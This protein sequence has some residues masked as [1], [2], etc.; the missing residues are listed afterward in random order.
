MGF[1]SRRPLLPAPTDSLLGSANDT[2]VETDIGTDL[3]R[4][5]DKTSDTIPA[6]GTPITIAT[7]PKRKTPNKLT[8][9]RQQSQTS[10]LIEYFE[11][12]KAVESGQRRPSLRVR[13]TPSQSRKNKEKGEGHILVTES[14][15]ARRPSQSHRIVL[16]GNETLADNIVSSSISALDPLDNLKPHAPVEVE[17]LN[18]TESELSERSASPE[19]RYIVPESDISSMPAE[20]SLGPHQPIFMAS[21]THSDNF[22]RSPDGAMLKPPVIM[23]DRNSSQ[24][25]ITQKV[26]E[27]LSNKPRAST[28][29]KR[30]SSS[31]SGS[32]STGSREAE[33]AISEP[34][35]RLTKATDGDFV[36]SATNS[37][38][39]S[40]SHLSADPR[41]ADQ[42]SVRSGTSNV[43]ISNNPKLLKT[44]ED[45]IRRL[46]LP[47]LDE[48]RRDQKHTHRS[49]QE[50]LSNPSDVSSSTISREDKARR[51]SSGS[52]SARRVSRESE[53]GV[54]SGSSRRYKQHKSLDYDSPSEQSYEQSESAESNSIRDEKRSHKRKSHRTR[55]VAAG[56]LGG[57]AL[58]AAALKSHDSGSSLDHSEH[59]RRR[60]S[61][62]RSSRSASIAEKEDAFRKHRVPPMPFVSELGTD[63]TRSSIKSSHDGRETPTRREVREVIR[64]SPLESQSSAFF[65]PT[66]NSFDLK[67]GLGTHHGNFSEHDLSG[68]DISTRK[69]IVEDEEVYR[70][71]EG[72][73]GDFATHGFAALTDPERARAY[74]RNLHQ[75]HPIRRGL[76]PIQSVAS[77]QTTEPNRNSMMQQRSSETIGSFKKE[78]QIDDQVSI[79]SLSSPPST[80]LARSRRPHGISLENRSEIMAQHKAS[81]HSTPRQADPEAVFDEQHL[82]NESYRDAPYIDKVTAGQQLAKVAGAT[83]EYFEYPAGVE[84]AVASLVDPSVLDTDYNDSARFSQ[85]DS[86]TAREGRSPHYSQPGSPLKHEISQYGE[87]VPTGRVTMASPPQSPARSIEHLDDEL[88]ESARSVPGPEADADKDNQ[89]ERSPDSDITTNPSIIRGPIGGLGEGNTDH[90]PYDPTPPHSR[91]EA[92]LPPVSRDIHSAGA[93]LIPEALS[94]S[95]DHDL[96][97][98]DDFYTRTRSLGTPTSVKDEGYETGA[99]ARSPGLY[100]NHQDPRHENDPQY[101]GLKNP[102]LEDD[103]FTGKREKYVSGLSHGLSPMYDSATGRG[104]DNIQSKDIVALM[105]HLTTRDAQRNARDTEILV[106]LVRSAAEM[107][108]S[109]EDMKKFIAEQDD[110]VMDTAEKQHER[111][112]K[113]VGGP[114]PQPTATPRTVQS[115][116]PE[117]DMPSKRR[118]VFQRALRGLG[119]KNTQELQNIE[120]MLMRLLDEVEALRTIQVPNNTPNK[121][122]STSLASG[123]N[124]RPLTDTGYE[125][126]GQAG[127]SSTGDRSGFFSNN[128]SRQA[129]HRNY[130]LHRDSGNRVSTVIE[131]DEEY[132][133]Y[134]MPLGE[135]AAGNVQATVQ[136]P[137]RNEVNQQARAGSA[138]LKTP[139]RLHERNTGSLSNE[140][141]PHYSAGDGSGRKH[142]SSASSFVPKMFSRWSKTTTSSADNYRSSTQRMRPQSEMSRSGSDLGEY[143]FEHDPQGDDR[144]RSQHSLQQD[145]YQD[146]ENRPPSPLIPSQMSDNPKY[147]AHRNS[148][149]L[150]HPQPR[151]G[152]TGRFQSR[153]ESEAQL[154]NNQISPTSQTSSQFETYAGLQEPNGHAAMYGGHQ[155]PMSDTQYDDRSVHSASSQGPPRPPKILNEDPL[156]PQRPPKISMNSTQSNRQHTYVD[157]VAAARAGS[158]AL[159][160]S[161]VAALRSPQGQTRKPSGPRPLNTAGGPKG[162]SVTVKRAHFRSSPT[163]VDS[164]DEN[165]LGY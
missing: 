52:K 1:T 51:R 37:S 102:P 73:D 49:R 63:I 26:I 140:N 72:E 35:I 16:G 59:R 113:V 139:P 148:M 38:L 98:T 19:P 46:I 141:T 158:P 23:A 15:T 150:Q 21:S 78:Q 40:G 47:E 153:L 138:P 58:T 7:A 39:L 135:A 83:P 86:F 162:G 124:A 34:R 69:E 105:D 2:G 131:G 95:R 54:P 97:P 64:G 5:T 13:Y 159:D 110:M 136:T 50:K 28:S 130:S 4:R 151:Q 17:V 104:R 117:E 133:D 165:S 55:D 88:I 74:E 60:R 10:L 8:K 147:Q 114:R 96:E 3:S 132:D 43:S 87:Y 90:W 82:E 116:T 142:K 100:S 121:P 122:R 92:T 9:T 119:A 25:R 101:L 56:A 79:S 115:V 160:K 108:N 45:V 30:H 156:V 70:S 109:F 80:D 89:A 76:S 137:P 6:D 18:S 11:G 128:S 31:H 144:L 145:R 42:G 111:T 61:K 57:A 24:E 103:P 81:P 12:S 152:P 22:V 93:D 41:A 99:N 62:S 125:P 53:S 14:P 127:T 123:D 157:H 106:T 77:Y 94:I 71:H 154:Y 66:R 155:S 29:G 118:N 67:R 129:D 65:T 85:A 126:E 36:P 143:E 44:V 91:V 164:D 75:Q 33:A 163:Q 112:Q 149:N 68:H 146:Q 84:S 27:K 134:G 107:R 161:P 20:S 120:S 32:R 48:I